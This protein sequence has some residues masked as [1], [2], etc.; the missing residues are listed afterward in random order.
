MLGEDIPHLFHQHRTQVV[1]SIMEER[2]GERQRDKYGKGGEN[3]K[4]NVIF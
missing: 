3:G 4:L 2:E 1:L